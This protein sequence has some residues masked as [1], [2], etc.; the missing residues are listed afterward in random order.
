MLGNQMLQD[1][2]M[3]AMPIMESTS[4]ITTDAN[5][6]LANI[7]QKTTDIRPMPAIFDPSKTT[8]KG[9]NIA[10]N[11]FKSFA[12]YE[13][14]SSQLSNPSATSKP[15]LPEGK[16]ASGVWATLTDEKPN[17]PAKEESS[18]LLGAVAS[19]MPNFF[20]SGETYEPWTPLEDRKASIAAGGSLPR[21][22]LARQRGDSASTVKASKG[23]VSFSTPSPSIDLETTQPDNN[24][25]WQRLNEAVRTVC[26]L[27][28]RYRNPSRDMETSLCDVLLAEDMS[29][30]LL[31]ILPENSETM[32]RA[33]ASKLAEQV[34]D[35]LDFR[36][37][38]A[39]STCESYIMAVIRTDLPRHVASLHTNL[40][41]NVIGHNIARFGHILAMVLQDQTHLEQVLYVWLDL[42]ITLQ[43]MAATG[44]EQR[45]FQSINEQTKRYLVPLLLIG[46]CR[47]HLSAAES[48][49]TLQNCLQYCLTY[50]EEMFSPDNEV[51]LPKDWIEQALH[52]LAFGVSR[53]AGHLRGIAMQASINLER[54]EEEEKKLKRK[55]V[56][57]SRLSTPTA[58]KIPSLA[59]PSTST[60]QKPSRMSFL[61]RDKTDQG[62]KKPLK[63][64]EI[65]PAYGAIVSKGNPTTSVPMI[66]ESTMKQ[67]DSSVQ[68]KK[69]TVS[70][71]SV[72]TRL[73]KA[74]TVR[75]SRGAASILNIGRK[76]G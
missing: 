57:P 37:Q 31:A 35:G 42:T 3:T 63:E 65:K 71:S 23:P 54:H 24:D 61:R 18:G 25:M 29:D 1:S 48:H 26:A 34:V 14:S 52:S 15:I 41:D 16:D 44:E 59:Q 2:M 11:P 51:L 38:A 58:S 19:V 53:F 6:H 20:G 22:S 74:D 4:D 28:P 49:V 73:S 32:W 10:L 69:R 64:A 68:P 56:K 21:G 60:V 17:S 46:A 43:M 33:E 66:R 45:F 13:A 7:L 12:A 9:K 27:P 75:G 40:A 5:P 55:V 62:G 50:K 39:P 30:E 36:A 70:G 67:E 72:W 76:R 47:K 8:V